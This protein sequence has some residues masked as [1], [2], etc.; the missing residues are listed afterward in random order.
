MPSVPEIAVTAATGATV[1]IASNNVRHEV[2]LR[3]RGDRTWLGFNEDAV[4]NQGI[5]LDDGDAVV[6]A[7][8]LCMSDIYFVSSGTAVIGAQL[9]Y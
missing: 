9:V 8:P 2:L 6:I 4:A 3:S 7:E 5:W 1:A